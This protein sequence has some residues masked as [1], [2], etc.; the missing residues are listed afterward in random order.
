MKT[1]GKTLPRFLLWGCAVISLIVFAKAHGATA[2]SAMAYQ[3]IVDRNA[4]GLRPPLPIPEVK[5][6]KPPA[7][8]FTLTGIITSLLGDKRVMMKATNPETLAERPY[9]LAEGQ[10]EGDI[11][12]LQIDEA[13]GEVKI[14][15]A[16]AVLLL[17][18]ENNGPKGSAG[19]A[20]N[21]LDS[22]APPMSPV[23]PPRTAPK[24]QAKQ[25]ISPEQ[26]AILLAAQH[27]E[28]QNRGMSLPPPPPPITELL[29]GP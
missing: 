11:E 10:R 16:G 27:L 3:G 7:I 1:E 5:V 9:I 28:A 20:L 8:R 19:R 24:P 13:L 15:H 18:W 2:S 25:F 29:D 22:P 17:D 14:K 12:V 23:V 6:L 26:Q 4:F 21:P